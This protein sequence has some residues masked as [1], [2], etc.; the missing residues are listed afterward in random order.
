MYSSNNNIDKNQILEEEE[1][2]YSGQVNHSSIFPK[3]D[4]GGSVLGSFIKQL[5]PGMDL[6]QLSCPSFILS[7]YSYL[8]ARTDYCA[9]IPCLLNINSDPNPESRF[10]RVCEWVISSLTFTPSNNGVSGMKPYNPVLGER[11]FC[12]FQ[13]S[14]SYQDATY[15]FAEQVSH[16]PPVTAQFMVNHA[17]QFIFSNTSTFSIKF[18]YASVET[19]IASLPGEGPSL[20]LTGL[21]EKYEIEYPGIVVTG[22]VFGT[23]TVSHSGE[24]R[25]RCLKTGFELKADCVTKKHSISGDIIKSNGKKICSIKGN[26]DGTVELTD[27]RYRT[28][29]VFIDSSRIPFPMKNVKPVSEQEEMESRRVW[30]PVTVALKKK[31]L[32]CCSREKNMIEEAQ[33][34][35]RSLL[36]IENWQ[37]VWFDRFMDNRG[38]IVYRFKQSQMELKRKSSFSQ[39]LK[40]LSLA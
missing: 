31:D 18:K 2:L 37:P 22:L 29:R 20:L 6:V 35:K 30:H 12:T 16:H 10:L 19:D 33:R 21:D 34:H 25:V 27:K 23:T 15:A 14:D 32:E 13:H 28:T 36:N 11:F 1:A 7:P 4:V 5:R 3:E 8:E 39:Y 17:H 40:N 9:P 38:N 26:L 24:L